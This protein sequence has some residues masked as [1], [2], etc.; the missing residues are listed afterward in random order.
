[1]TAGISLFSPEYLY[2][3]GLFIRVLWRVADENIAGN[4]AASGSTE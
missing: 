1:M 3:P 2:L 4:D